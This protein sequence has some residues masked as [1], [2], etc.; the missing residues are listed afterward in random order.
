MEERIKLREPI[1]EML[2]MVNWK[3]FEDFVSNIFESNDFK[4]KKNFRFRTRRRY[5][6]DLIAVRGNIC[7]CVDCK[8][9][10]RGRYKKTA[11]KKAVQRQEERTNEFL[12]FLERNPL[13]ASSFNLRKA[14]VYPLIVTLFEEEMVKE[15]K[16][17]IIPVWKLNSFLLE[18][19]RYI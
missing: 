11:L 1:E 14:K 12:R 3:D 9:W 17:F 5:E 13:A 16:T 6:L 19:E 10:G 4:V 15:G 7:F 8:E 18:M 2:K